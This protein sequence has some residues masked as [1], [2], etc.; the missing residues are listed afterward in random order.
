MKKLRY[1]LVLSFNRDDSYVIHS[2]YLIQNLALDLMNI[3]KYSLKI[4]WLYTIADESPLQL[5]ISNSADTKPQ[6]GCFACHRT[7]RGSIC[8]VLEFHHS[9]EQL[10]QDFVC[11][12]GVLLGCHCQSVSL[13]HCSIPCAVLHTLWV[14]S[15]SWTSAVLFSSHAVSMHPC[16]IQLTDRHLIFSLMLWN[17]VY[18]DMVKYI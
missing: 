1:I 11:I 15:Y 18:T 9:Q 2:L 13:P 16:K 14:H 8:F 17:A 3:T 12:K 7:L 5:N 6:Q 10:C 4:H